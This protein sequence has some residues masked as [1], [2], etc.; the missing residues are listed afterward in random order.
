MD[1]PNL[2]V[3]W[4]YSHDEI[5]TAL[6]EEIVKPID[7]SQHKIYL[8]GHDWGAITTHAFLVKHPTSITKCIFFGRWVVKVI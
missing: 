1:K 2:S 8:V 3:F 6:Y 5:S 7:S 4:G